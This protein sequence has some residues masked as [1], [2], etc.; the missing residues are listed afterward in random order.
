M[1][2]CELERKCMYK[3]KYG[4]CGASGDCQHVNW[5]DKLLIKYDKN[6]ENHSDFELI[7]VLE[8]SQTYKEKTIHTTN[9]KLIWLA[10]GLIRTKNIKSKDIMF[11]VDDL[12]IRINSDGDFIDEMYLEAEELQF[13]TVFCMYKY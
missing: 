9:S 13:E 6:G 3:T 2:N 5:D 10:Q 8:W 4:S 11:V 12:E 7:D 1:K